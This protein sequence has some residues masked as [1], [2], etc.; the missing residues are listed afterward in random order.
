MFL[1]FKVFLRF[2]LNF[3]TAGRIFRILTNLAIFWG[4]GR[5]RQPLWNHNWLWLW[6]KPICDSTQSQFIRGGMSTPPKIRHRACTLLAW[7]SRRSPPSPSLPAFP[8]TNYLVYNIGGPGNLA[9]R[10]MH[11]YRTETDSGRSVES[12]APVVSRGWTRVHPPQA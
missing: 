4:R 3:D 12:R 6:L 10:F 11:P 2:S 9:F 1:T 8:S 5:W 7:L